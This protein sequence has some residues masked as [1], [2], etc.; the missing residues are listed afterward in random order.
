M[1]T[2]YEDRSI[3]TYKAQ[4]L[5]SWPSSTP[6]PG[7][8]EQ[9]RQ[10]LTQLAEEWVEPFK[11]L[12]EKIPD[13]VELKTVVLDD[14]IRPEDGRTATGTNNVLLMGDSGHTMTMCKSLRGL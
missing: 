11:S 13:S 10:F 8:N 9:R 5:I 12:I 4:I 3:K 2:N 1:P 7:T 6:V 14:W